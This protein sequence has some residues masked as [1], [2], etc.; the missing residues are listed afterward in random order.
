MYDVCVTS[1]RVFEVLQV[2]DV[3]VTPVRVFEALQ[4]YDVWVT[5]CAGV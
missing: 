2:F 1:V 5:C 4:V 3:C